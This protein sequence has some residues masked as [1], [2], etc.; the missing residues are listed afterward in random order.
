MSQQTPSQALS[1]FEMNFIMQCHK[2]NFLN[3]SAISSVLYTKEFLKEHVASDPKY[4]SYRAKIE[5][6]LLRIKSNENNPNQK[7]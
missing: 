2:E 3:P 7:K 1:D 4:P 5:K 6:E